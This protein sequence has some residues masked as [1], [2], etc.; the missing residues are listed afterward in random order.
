MTRIDA[1]AHVIETPTTWSYM[2]D[3]EQEFRPKIFERNPNDGAPYEAS[4]RNQYWVVGEKM[5]SKGNNI[6]HD[7]PREAQLLEDIERRLQHMDEIG[8]DIQVLF[9]S[10]FLRPITTEPDVEYALVRS[11]NRWLAGIWREGNGRLRWIMCPPLLSLA[12]HGLVREE[13]EFCKENGACGIF[14]RGFECER[15]L[16]HRYF[17]PLYEMA[18]EF[19][20]PITLH[21][22]INSAP[23]HD[24]LVNRSGLLTFKFPVIGAFHCLLEDGIPERF[25]GVRWAFVETSAQWLPY[26]LGEARINIPRKGRRPADDLLGEN[27][28]YVT[29]QK[30]DDLRGLIDEVGDSNL[31]IGTDYGHKDVA[32]ELE[33]I[34]RLATDGVIHP[35]SARKILQ[36]NPSRLYGIT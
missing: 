6:G 30:T 26:V 1:D 34:K 11:Y 24:M 2:R 7:V 22:G 9:T 19:D 36:D 5:L 8:V 32:T 4:G 17:F 27:N 20:M 12:D 25:P 14:M 29:T 18:Q 10:V 28:M 35:D 31:L 15:H 13:L 16:S 3:H 23:Y 33:A 21:A